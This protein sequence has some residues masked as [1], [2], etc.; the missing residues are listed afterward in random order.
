MAALDFI[1]TCRECCIVQTML[2]A[3]MNPHP[4][5]T[6]DTQASA[7]TAIFIAH[8]GGEPMTSLSTTATIAGVGLEGDRYALG[9]GYYSK[10]DPCEVTLIESETL[11]VI[12]K[13][14][15]VPIG[16]GQHRRNLVTRGLCLRELAGRQFQIGGVL[17]QYDRPRPPCAYLER[18]S[19][20]GMTRAIGEG[21]GIAARI[22][23]PGVIRVRDRIHVVPGRV[24]SVRRLP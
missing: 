19:S 21:A 23:Q 16:D 20:P 6:T 8:L 14:F 13:R 18:V 24:G 4:Q 3:C 11:E 17:L 22:L 2:K 10:A 15:R 9:R 12:A 7:L 1:I 5:S